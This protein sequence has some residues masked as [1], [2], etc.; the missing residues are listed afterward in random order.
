MSFCTI[1]LPL[2]TTPYLLKSHLRLL[3]YQKK[4][5]KKKNP[6]KCFAYQD[7]DTK[8]LVWCGIDS[9]LY[10]INIFG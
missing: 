2:D 5:K 7:F 8:T 1:N 4:E 6:L 9:P 10:V 3:F